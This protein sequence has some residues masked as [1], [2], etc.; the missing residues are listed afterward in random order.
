MIEDS[1][2]KTYYQKNKIKLR[3]YQRKYY[4]KKKDKEKKP[5]APKL[6]TMKR[7]FG[8]FTLTWD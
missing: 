5:K 3:E 2:H 1:Y 6:K 7:L 4:H 8:T